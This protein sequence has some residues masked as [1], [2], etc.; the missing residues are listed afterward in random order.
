MAGMAPGDVILICVLEEHE[1]F[2][3]QGDDLMVLQRV[4]LQVAICGG[5]IEVAHLS[6]RT[7]IARLPRGAV[8]APGAVKCLPGEGMPKRH[9]PHLRGD[10]VPPTALVV[11]SLMESLRRTRRP[12]CV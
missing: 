7:V 3:R 9:N 12:S 1:R 11:R 10:L 5:A 2:F 6:G 4:P 8:L